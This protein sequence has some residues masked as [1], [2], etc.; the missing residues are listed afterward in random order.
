MS[1]IRESAWERKLMK[2]PKIENPSVTHTF[3]QAAEDRKKIEDRSSDVICC[4]SQISSTGLPGRGSAL[5][6]A[7]VGTDTHQRLTTG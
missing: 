7:A 2:D 5:Y 6:T 3:D 1:D 4:C